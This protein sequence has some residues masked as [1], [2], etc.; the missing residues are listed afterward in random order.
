MYDE[1]LSIKEQIT[2]VNFR[3]ELDM[4]LADLACDSL[5]NEVDKDHISEIYET[6]DRM[7]G[8]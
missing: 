6:M 5:V 7:V 3:N 4:M 2:E 1:F 8:E